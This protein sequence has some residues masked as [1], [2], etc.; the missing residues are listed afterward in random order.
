MLRLLRM[1]TLRCRYALYFVLSGSYALADSQ[2]LPQQPVTVVVTASKLPEAVDGVPAMISVVTGDDLRSRG[3][4]DLRTALSLV[5]G[6]DIAPGGDAGPAS[7]APGMWGLRE[8][9][10]Y[11]LVVDGV[12]YGGAFNPA[13]TTLNLQNI[14]RIEVL[15]GAAP[16]MYGAT[17]FV[18]VIHIINRAAGNLPAQAELM[19]GS[20]N[21]KA[22][23]LSGNLPDW[24]GVRQSLAINVEQQGFEQDRSGVKRGHLLYRSATDSAFG[25]LRIDVAADVLRQQ[26]Y[27]PHPREGQ[28]LTKRFALD[29]NVNPQDAAADQDRVQVTGAL[30]NSLF[31]SPWQTTISTAVTRAHNTRGY[32]RADFATDGVTSNADGFRQVVDATDVYFDSHIAVTR[33]PSLT[34]LFGVDWLYGHGKQ[35]SD[36]FE[37]AIAVNGVA[38]PRSSALQI[39]ESTRL[40]DRRSFGGLYSQLNWQITP[41]TSLDVGVRL[42]RT[43]EHRTGIAVDRH[44]DSGAQTETDRHTLTRLSG[45]FGASHVVWGHDGSAVT[46]FA[47]YRNSFKPAAID[48][49]PEAE[50]HILDSESARSVEAGLKGR[51]LNSRLE[52][53]LA[54]FQMN[55]ANLVIKENIAGRPALANA[56]RERFRGAEIEARYQITERFRIVSTLAHHDARFVDYTRLRPDGSL[57]S[58][59]GKQLE[60]SPRTL[61]AAGFVYAD[62]HGLETSITWNYVGSRFLNKTNTARS[63]GYGMLDARIGWQRDRWHVALTGNNLTNRRDPVAESEIGD[64]Q[65]YRL[66]GRS[67]NLAVQVPLRRA[68]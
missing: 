52:W 7:A 48:F 66:P 68:R 25:V 16:V 23:T 58:L 13:V 14:E 22:A 42:N 20:P 4:R 24:H 63:G 54:W 5:A 61:A 65:F 38:A 50:A 47:D 12:P 1:R 41:K 10:A 43:D 29:A 36:N 40:T 67:I 59:A 28:Q 55:F 19:G 62:P 17:S 2:P 21:N 30:D 26:P 8:F 51:M 49:G 34:W 35:A 33:Q 39:D 27:S 45:V 32:L 9:D 57:Q 64:A 18:G 46:A 6:V 3:A 11:L 56:G 15:R 60:L 31:N 44:T 37:Y 53:E